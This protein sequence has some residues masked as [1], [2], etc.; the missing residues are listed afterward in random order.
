MKNLTSK[1]RFFLVVILQTLILIGVAGYLKHQDKG[2]KIFLRIERYN[3]TSPLR[4]DYLVLDYPDISRI[5]S[6]KVD[7]GLKTG[8]IVYVPLVQQGKIF[9]L[10]KNARIGKKL[11][12]SGIFIKGIVK[13]GP[14][15][16]LYKGD[17]HSQYIHISYGIENYYI[18]QNSGRGI[19]W[20]KDDYAE[21]SLDS[22][23]N[24]SLVQVYIDGKPFP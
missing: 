21:I 14:G 18:P 23:G 1:M 4:G 22:R 6:S 19:K 9:T 20:G 2:L 8:D 17:I 16:I 3:P 13:S 10:E 7:L 11:P 12:Q 15:N 5:E 24:P